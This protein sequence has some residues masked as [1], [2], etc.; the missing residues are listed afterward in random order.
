M[1]AGSNIQDSCVIR[2]AATYPGEHDADTA[3]GSRVTIGHKA[4]LHGVTLEDEVLVGMAATLQQGVKV[5]GR[6]L[7]VGELVGW[8]GV[9]RMRC[10]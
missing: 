4:S 6:L 10:W 2:T 7:W 1:G 9:R 3:I 5:G 8:L